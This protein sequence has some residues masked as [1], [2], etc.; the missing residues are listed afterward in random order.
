MKI[1]PDS[2]Y[3][4]IYT[5][6]SIKATYLKALL[7]DEGIPPILRDDGDSARAGG[8][9]MDYANGV[10]VLVHKKDVLKAKYIVQ[11]A[12]DENGDIIA[13]SEDE[14]EKKALASNPEP[15]PKSL[16][17]T[18]QNQ[19]LKRSPLN[20]LLN[21]GLIV[22]SLWRLSPL[23]QGKELPTFRIVLSSVIIAAC[24]W[25]LFKHFKK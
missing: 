3:E 11:N 20:L 18:S 17:P 8:F 19:S 24:A 13:I 21:A 2:N 12:L 7:E 15:K 9:G 14:L 23:L 16:K 22:Y 10:K 4:K 1:I 6:S 25:T 5:G